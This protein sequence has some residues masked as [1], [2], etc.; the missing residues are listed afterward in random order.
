MAHALARGRNRSSWRHTGTC[1]KRVSQVAGHPARWSRSRLHAR[2]ELWPSA[3]GPLRRASRRGRPGETAEPGG[4][5][6]RRSVRAPFA[7]TMFCQ[8]RSQRGAEHAWHWRASVQPLAVPP[9]VV[10]V[11]LDHVYPPG[12]PPACSGMWVCSLR[13]ERC[14]M[15][16][17]SRPSHGSDD[18]GACPVTDRGEIIPVEIVYG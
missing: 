14:E 12:M 2:R 16:C 6:G 3:Q 5:T 18:S 17:R 7:R 9:L 15:L 4:E 11:S 1:V 8:P 10:C 13:I